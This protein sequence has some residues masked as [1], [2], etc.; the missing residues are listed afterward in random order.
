MAR[1]RTEHR[2]PSSGIWKRRDDPGE[3]FAIMLKRRTIALAFS[4]FVGFGIALHERPAAGHAANVASTTA[5]RT[6]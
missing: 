6:R 1:E 2:C 4:A 5:R 3:E